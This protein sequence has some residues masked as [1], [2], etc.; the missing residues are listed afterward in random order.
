[1][2]KEELLVMLQRALDEEENAIP[3]YTKHLST[4][5]FL[6]DFPPEARVRIKE[7]LLLLKKES[8]SHAQVYDRLLKGVRGSHQD[9]Y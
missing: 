5:L 1:M 6:S 9:V 8:E 3:L 4:T 7:L 2:T